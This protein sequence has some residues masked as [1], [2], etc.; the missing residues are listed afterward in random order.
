LGSATM[1]SGGG[2][3]FSLAATTP[4]AK[5]VSSNLI[6]GL[7][8]GTIDF[9]M[10]ENLVYLFPPFNI[11]FD[12]KWVNSKVVKTLIEVFIRKFFAL[13]INLS[14]VEKKSAMAKTQFVRKNFSSV[15]SFREATISSKFEEIIK[16]IFT[17][18]SS[19]KKTTS[20]TRE[21]EIVINTNLKKQGIYSD[22]A[23]VIKEIPMD[24][25]KKMIVTT[26]SEFGKIKLIKIQLIGIWQKTVVTDNYLGS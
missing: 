13:N 14:A 12:K 19:L 23:V 3:F 8:I 26:V 21:K 2:F 6:S 25:Q 15:N 16:F 24:T 1:S 22:Q 18:K 4:K 5:R 10:D 9:G 7:P 11:S 20:L 17:S